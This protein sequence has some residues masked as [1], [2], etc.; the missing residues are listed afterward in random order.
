MTLLKPRDITEE[1]EGQEIDGISGTLTWVS[2]YT[3]GKGKR[4]PYSIQNAEIQH[5]GSKIKLKIWNHREI[6]KDFI[7]KEIVIEGQKNKDSKVKILSDEY[8]NERYLVVELQKNTLMTFPGMDT[9]EESNQEPPEGEEDFY[10]QK[11]SSEPS[12]PV[13]EAPAH[14]SSHSGSPLSLTLHRLMQHKNLYRLCWKTAESLAGETGW[15]VGTTKDVATH[16]SM[17]LIKEGFLEKMSTKAMELPTPKQPAPEPPP[18]DPSVQEDAPVEVNQEPEVVGDW[19]CHLI[20]VKGHPH[21]GKVL[22]ELRDEILQ[23]IY[24]TFRPKPVDGAY[25][26]DEVRLANALITWNHEFRANQEHAEKPAKK[27]K[28]TK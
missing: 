2:K 26:T 1:M 28:K 22:G 5:S 15:D 4:G 25:N 18:E 16:F 7:N 17:T 27:T 23:G 3:A 21:D 6:T 9:H 20:K 11:G 19:K 14:E 13:K 24:E 8:K 12:K 10:P